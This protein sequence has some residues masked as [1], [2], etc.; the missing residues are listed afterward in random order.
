MGFEEV[1]REIFVC[2]FFVVN[3][4][5]RGVPIA[6][7]RNIPRKGNGNP[8]PLEIDQNSGPQTKTLKRLAI[9]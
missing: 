4:K 5:G 3:F 9:K 7:D 1:D 8:L 6:Y 2:V